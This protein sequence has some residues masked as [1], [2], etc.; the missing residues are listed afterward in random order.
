MQLAGKV[1]LVTGAASGLGAATAIACAK[2]GADVFLVDRDADG[3]ADTAARI[4]GLGRE[5]GFYQAD[6]SKRQACLDAVAAGISH[7]GKLDGL[8][9]IAG[10]TLFHRVSEVTEEDWN[11]TV[12]VILSAPF[13]LSQAALPEL[14][15][16]RTEISGG[17]RY[18]SYKNRSEKFTQTLLPPFLIGNPAPIILPKSPLAPRPE[19][20]YN[21]LI[22]SASIKHNFTDDLMVYAST[23]SSWRASAQTNGI[24]TGANGQNGFPW[25]TLAGLLSLPSEKSKS[26][27]I[28]FKSR[29]FDRKLL[30]NVTAYHQ[31]FSNYFYSAPGIYVVQRSA[32]GAGGSAS[33]PNP[34]DVYGLYLPPGPI[35]I[36][37]P[38]KVNGVEGEF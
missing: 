38:V 30:L 13:Y 27:E 36:G 20:V 12:A 24:I 18:I 17:L 22:Y 11:L 4:A 19:D 29:W 6:L 10:I 21:N 2:E 37:V 32:L 33:G 23:G 15:R 14:I 7:F 25:G 28:G 8:C 35:A 1:I 34:G 31:T 16:N 5:T 3:M 9:N 26:Y